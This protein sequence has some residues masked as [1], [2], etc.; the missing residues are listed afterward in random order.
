MKLDV[1]R[2]GHRVSDITLDDLGTPLAGLDISTIALFTV[3]I[4]I[5]VSG[6]GLHTSDIRL[7]IR[8]YYMPIHCK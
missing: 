3:D 4:E 7:V 1:R 8:A 5:L 2:T 6:T